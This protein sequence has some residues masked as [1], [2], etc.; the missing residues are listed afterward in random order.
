MQLIYFYIINLL[1]N[2]LM[3]RSLVYHKCIYCL[4]TNNMR[5]SYGWKFIHWIINNLI[6]DSY[7]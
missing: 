2:I 1:W 5:C 3:K 4:V 7:T 6:K